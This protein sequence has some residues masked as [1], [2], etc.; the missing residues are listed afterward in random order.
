MPVQVG[1][2]KSW[3]AYRT[4]LQ[5][6]PDKDPIPEFQAQLLKAL[7]TQ[8]RMRHWQAALN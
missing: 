5:E 1:Y 4:Y 2:V 7:Q 3:S 8:V 6:H